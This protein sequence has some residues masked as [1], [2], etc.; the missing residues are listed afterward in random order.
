MLGSRS[1]VAMVLAAL[2]LSVA[3]L[4]AG[5]MSGRAAASTATVPSLTLTG[6]VDPFMASYVQRGIDEATANHDPA[7]LMLI[8]TPGGLD[9]SMREITKAILASTTPVICYTSP[10]GARAA[11]AGMFVM[12]SCPV[13]AMAPGTNIGAAHPVG[14]Q[15]AIEMEKV[16]NDAAAYMRS[17]AEKWGRNADLAEKAVRDATSWS[18]E[19]ALGGHLV[20]VMEPNAT[21]LLNAAGACSGASVQTTTG[22]LATRGSLPGLCGA[23]IA[24]FGMSVTESLF[25]AFADP[26]VAFLLVNIGFLALIVWI[27]HPGLHVSLAIGIVALI[28]G[29]AILETLPVRL[30]GFAL[31]LVAAVLFVLDVKARAHGVLTA[32]GIAV[33]I[34]GGLLLFNPSVPTAH[35]SLWLI[36]LVGVSMGLITAF[37]LRA[38][39]SAKDEPAHSG[40]EL[41]IG[42]PGTVSSTLSPRGTVRARAETWTAESVGGPIPAGTPVRIVG[43]KGVRLIVEPA[44][45]PGTEAPVGAHSEGSDR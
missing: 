23:T 45:P 43:V 32:G 33:L 7:V 34:L 16:T 13:A 20:D 3:L 42:A 31:L 24:P 5:V 18:A 41:L 44:E 21:A 26:N 17:L 30:V 15:G 1:R 27:F 4:V 12:E 25:H 37:A 14:V 29:F 38:L 19:G 11:S 10:Q 6:V 8:D 35:V 2:W 39:L 40:M 22:L 36:I 9:S 28:L